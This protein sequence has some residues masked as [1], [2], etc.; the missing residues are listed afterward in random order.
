MADLR[1]N[2]L[3]MKKTLAWIV[4]FL[5]AVIICGFAISAI[6]IFFLNANIGTIFAVSAIYFGALVGWALH[7]ITE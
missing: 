6:C 2:L 3:T 4:I 1:F 7:A 5:A